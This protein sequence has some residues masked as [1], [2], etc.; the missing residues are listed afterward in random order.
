MKSVSSMEEKR[1]FVGM[2]ERAVDAQMYLS[3]YS[4]NASQY[5]LKKAGV[6]VER[7]N[8]VVKEARKLSDSLSFPVVGHFPSK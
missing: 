5:S 7:F 6:A 2:L 8:E 3:A 1:V 4:S